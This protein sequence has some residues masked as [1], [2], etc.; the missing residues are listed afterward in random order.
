MFAKLIAFFTKR[1]IVIGV[2]VIA[3]AGFLI[4]LSL[5]SGGPI[6]NLVT[7][8][9]GDITQEVAITGKVEPVSNIDLAFE[10]A[11]RVVGVNAGVGDK[12]YA[13][14]TLVT[15][16]SSELAAQLV[17]AQANVATQQAQLDSLQVDKSGQDLK[18]D[19]SSVLNTLNDSYAKADDAVRNQAGQFFT[20]T[21]SRSPQ[22]IFAVNDSQIQSDI[23]TGRVSAGTELVT[24]KG[25]LNNLDA[26]SSNAILDQ[27]INNA[28]AHL[29]VV[30]TFLNRIM[31]AV[32]N[33]MSLSQATLASYKT[34]ITTARAEVN[35]AIT[36]VNTLAETI[37]SQ[38]LIV[39]QSPKDIDAQRAQLTQAQANVSLIRA[40]LAKTVLRSPI[41][42]TVTVQNANVGE[43]ASTNTPITS[44]ISSDRLQ[45]EAN[46]TEADIA[47]VKIDDPVTFTLD[48]YG[49][50]VT[51]DANVIS[52]DP[53]ETVI[54]GV[55]TYKTDFKLAKEDKRIKPGMT[56]NLTIVTNKHENVLT[57]PQ[58][59]TFTKNGRVLVLVPD[60][61][62]TA[63]R[64]IQT[65]LRGAN[66]N[67]EIIGGLNEGDK[68]VAI[69]VTQ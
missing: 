42:G 63:E 47:K 10:K 46:I 53:A 51:F 36:N 44:I 19:Y 32:I 20:N 25:E 62:G 6:Q 61:K 67:I 28:Q 54:E 15:L 38:K 21:D 16:D 35:T 30:S 14:E 2:L 52:I 50:N 8:T 55:A 57:V 58:R 5:S 43:I 66:G 48:A 22:L 24:W 11:G 9:R 7:V 40:Q 31:D 41:S 26:T 69:P 4:Y 34:D 23:Q 56:A 33:S 18:N 29:K 3:V 49:D 59:S 45:I 12:V 65:G 64:E 17:Q 37:A 68:I 27:A 60:G 1:N 13:G 39:Q